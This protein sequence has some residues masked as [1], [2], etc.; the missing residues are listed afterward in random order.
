LLS[1]IRLQAEMGTQLGRPPGP[2]RESLERISRLAQDAMEQVRALSLRLHPPEWQRLTLEAA[3][4]ELWELSG[5]PQRFESS[6]RIQAFARQPS[7][8]LKTLA[9]RAA[10][11]ALSNI[12]RHAHATRVEASL[13]TRGNRLALTIHDNGAGFDAAALLSA[14]PS[15]AAGIG[16]RSIREQAAALGGKLT[17]ESGPNGTTLELLAPFFRIQTEIRD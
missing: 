15:L 8:E 4:R 1:A 11:E 2:A 5:I 12:A 7:L 13:E 17:V 16:L 6:L 3:I 9:Y 14:P 10:Q